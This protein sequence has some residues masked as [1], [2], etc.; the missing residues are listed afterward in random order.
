LALGTASSS[1]TERGFGMIV[2]VVAFDK[3]QGSR[4]SYPCEGQQYKENYYVFVQA[5][6]ESG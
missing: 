2:A 3:T 5:S 1:L 6:C 4:Y